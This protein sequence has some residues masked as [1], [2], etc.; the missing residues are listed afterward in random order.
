MHDAGM[1]QGDRAASAA[2]RL[3]DASNA[4][5]SDRRRERAA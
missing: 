5:R 3:D 1:V 4:E 2:R